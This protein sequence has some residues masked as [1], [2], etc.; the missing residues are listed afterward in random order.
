MS[1]K[2]SDVI[3]LLVGDEYTSTLDA[4]RALRPEA[5]ANAQA[6][7]D[8]LFEPHSTHALSLIER[9][10]VAAFVAGLHGDRAVRN[11]YAEGLAHQGAS[12]ALREAIEA[13]ITAGRTEGPYGRYIDGPLS[14]E[15]AEGLRYQPGAANRAALGERLGTAFTHAHLLVFRP[16]EASGEA[17]QALLDAGWTEDG[18]VTLSQLVAFLSF[19]IRLVTGLRVLAGTQPRQADRPTPHLVRA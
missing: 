17:L 8:A 3:D 19:Q 5:R 9:F 13:E 6:S 16:R 14:G 12:Q 2:S 15:S 4:L 7:Y 10:A 1:F 18:I 11:Y